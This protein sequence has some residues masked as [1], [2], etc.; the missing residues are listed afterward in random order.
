[1]SVDKFMCSIITTEHFAIT[2]SLYKKKL[3]LCLEYSPG[4]FFIAAATRSGT[5]SSGRYALAGDGRF[6]VIVK[7]LFYVL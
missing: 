2:Y 4:H 1:M 7:N 5:K 6:E 3:L